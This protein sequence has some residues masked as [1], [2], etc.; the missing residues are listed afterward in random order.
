[1]EKKVTSSVAMGVLVA[2][3][4]V[5]CNLVVHF[6]GL[7]REMWAAY[8]GFALLFIAAIV[9]VI[10]HAK[11]TGYRGSFGNLFSFGF[12]TTAATICLMVLYTILFN[13]IFPEAKAKYLELVRERSL[14][15]PEATEQDV[16]RLV[17]WVSNNY[18]LFSVIGIVFWFLVL[19]G[20][21]SL[22][23][24]AVSKKNQPATDFDNI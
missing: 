5:V 8:S 6:S 7:W 17:D 21:G 3:I 24:A 1:M 19:G 14:Q 22:I 4:L 11:E 20:V 18:I 23:G 15:R 13:L 10:L 2:L 16:T 9:V 12:R